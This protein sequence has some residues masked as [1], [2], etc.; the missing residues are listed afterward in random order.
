MEYYILAFVLGTIVSYMLLK[1]EGSNSIN[2]V[3]R[4]VESV[5]NKIKLMD[6]S[7][8][9]M[10]LS[11]ANTS[12][13]VNDLKTRVEKYVL[14]CGEIEDE[15]GKLQDHCVKLREQQI[16]LQ[17][18]ISKLRPVIRGAIP[19]QIVPSEKPKGRGVEALIK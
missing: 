17:E 19:V 2:S 13:S 12:I 6:D 10:N 5:F 16:E 18:K 8:Q 11:N 1:Y 7:I 14:F 9:K 4:K 3:D 15:T